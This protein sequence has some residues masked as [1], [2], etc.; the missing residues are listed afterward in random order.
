MVLEPT[1][2]QNQKPQDGKRAVESSLPDQMI[3]VYYQVCRHR[4]FDVQKDWVESEGGMESPAY[5]LKANDIRLMPLN[6]LGWG[7]SVLG[8]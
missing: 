3:I 5:L 6:L 7:F 8:G 4:L 1:P 2:R